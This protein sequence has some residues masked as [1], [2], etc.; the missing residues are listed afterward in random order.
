MWI[1]SLEVIVIT[2]IQKVEYFSSRHHQHLLRQPLRNPQIHLDC[3]LR[4]LLLHRLHLLHLLHHLQV[5]VLV[6]AQVQAQ[7]L[8]RLHCHYHHHLLPHCQRRHRRLLHYLHRRHYL[9]HCFQSHILCHH[10]HD[11]SHVDP[12]TVPGSFQEPPRRCSLDLVVEMVCNHPDTMDRSQYL[13][14]FLL[15]LDLLCRLMHCFQSHILCHHYRC[16]QAHEDQV[17]IP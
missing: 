5:Q 2:T 8:H 4:R 13:L 15:G 12:V 14:L 7:V 3:F 9:V 1:R 16:H 17:A 10:Y 6:P 11:Q